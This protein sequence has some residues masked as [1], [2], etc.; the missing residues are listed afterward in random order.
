MVVF[1]KA[2]WHDEAPGDK[3]DDVITPFNLTICADSFEEFVYRFWLENSI[4]YALVEERKLTDTQEAYRR[5]AAS[6]A[7]QA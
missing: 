6:R 1:A 7:P 4:W 3:L 5:T 2:E